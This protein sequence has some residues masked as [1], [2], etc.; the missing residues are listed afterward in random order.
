MNYSFDDGGSATHTQSIK[1]QTNIFLAVVVAANLAVLTW[2]FWPTSLDSYEGCMERAA[3]KA[4]GNA[5]IFNRLAQ[6]NCY[7]LSPAHLEQETKKLDAE[8]F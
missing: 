7:K 8:I 4:K 6:S 2:T 1:R 3:E 5:T